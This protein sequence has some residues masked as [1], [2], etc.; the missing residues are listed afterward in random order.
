MADRRLRRVRLALQE[1]V[2][3]LLDRFEQKYG[4]VANAVNLA[5]A[6]ALALEHADRF[7]D[8]GIGG[9]ILLGK[10]SI[11]AIREFLRNEVILEREEKKV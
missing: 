1:L 9:S 5:D 6:S 8:G 3:L 4:S 2:L 7:Q 11:A 10:H